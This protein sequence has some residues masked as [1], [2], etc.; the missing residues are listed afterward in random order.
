MLD[1]QKVRPWVFAG[2]EWLVRHSDDPYIGREERTVGFGPT[3]VEDLRPFLKKAAKI[4]GV[5]ADVERLARCE[6][7]MQA[8]L[9]GHATVALSQ[10]YYL[11]ITHSLANKGEALSAIAKLL[12]IPLAE[13]AVIGDGRNDVAMFRRSGLSIAMGNASPEVKA[14]ADF[15]TA[16]NR[17]DGFAHA[18]ERFILG[19]ER[20][21]VQIAKVCAGS[22]A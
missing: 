14:A 7:E 10:P 5:S 11:D 6:G 18:V 21:N 15:V 19:G 4:V 17:D 2:K 3:I 8:G 12:A 20:S 13:I 9:A 1:A 16:S 22:P